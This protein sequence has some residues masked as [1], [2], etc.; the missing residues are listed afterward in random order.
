MNIPYIEFNSDEISTFEGDAQSNTFLRITV[1]KGNAQKTP[2][3]D[4]SANNI[5][6]NSQMPNKYEGWLLVKEGNV[7]INGD[8]KL[9]S[10]T[11]LPE[12]NTLF[13]EKSAFVLNNPNY[14]VNYSKSALLTGT[15]VLNQGNFSIG[16][17]DEN[18]F[19]V[20]QSAAISINGGVF[21]VAGKM[22]L[23][24]KTFAF[25]EMNDGEFNIGDKANVN[26]KDYILN[27]TATK[28]LLNGGKINL[29][30]R[31]S[32]SNVKDFMGNADVKN[33]VLAIGTPFQLN[34]TFKLEG[35]LPTLI[36]KGGATATFTNDAVFSYLLSIEKNGRLLLGKQGAF[37]KKNL[38]NAGE[39]ICQQGKI[40]F[41]G[42]EAQTIS[43]NGLFGTLAYPIQNLEIKNEKGVSVLTDKNIVIQNL[44]LKAGNLSH[45]N[46][47]LLS[48]P[49]EKISITRG[50][51]SGNFVA[52]TLSKTPQYGT[53]NDLSLVYINSND[54]ML[55]GEE[56]PAD[57]QVAE[58]TINTTKNFSLTKNIGI[59]KNLKLEKGKIILNNF[60]LSASENVVLK[61]NK[62][63]YIVTNGEGHLRQVV[64]AT[65]VSF[66]IGSSL[67]S[68]DPVVLKNDGEADVFEVKVVQN[69][70]NVVNMTKI[71]NRQWLVKELV[72]GKSKLSVQLTYDT[73]AV[74]GN[75]F[76]G[77]API[78]IAVS[79]SNVWVEKT[80]TYLGFTAS[81][82][83]ITEFESFAI[84]NKSAFSVANKLS[85]LKAKLIGGN[86]FLTWT[87][88]EEYNN[89]GFEI[90]KSSDLINFEKIAFVESRGNNTT[91]ANYSFT[92]DNF[93]K[94]SYYRLKQINMSDGK[95]RYSN[96]AVLYKR[97]NNDLTIFPNPVKSG[98]PVSIKSY[99]NKPYNLSIYD[100]AGR[101][102][103]TQM[104]EEK[105]IILDTSRYESGVYWVHT[106]DE[107]GLYSISKLIIVLF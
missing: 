83:N 79:N 3:L 90:E 34:H 47:L 46:N 84:G 27:L 39:I 15:L 91:A 105:T 51:D 107:N 75:E 37:I 36:I 28:C 103:H 43:G 29:Q 99:E 80:A 21:T 2:N 86:T 11:F 78:F 38:D 66:P 1:D 58:M 4:I 12:G 50:E 40:V 64:A 33:T 106:S 54:M 102:M 81:I 7:S 61:G 14:T 63:A 18:G 59:S 53:T 101:L 76:D 9:S 96:V 25:F 60:N 70:V 87:T 71:V 31:N 16:N 44:F 94:T 68:Y 93:K 55:S 23:E 85:E 97:E 65:K 6:A 92:D 57:G 77:K 52:G 49:T 88:F 19:V 5:F 69:V 13:P 42:D 45:N 73:K 30:T 17:D 98:L 8:F 41:D 10:P 24:N 20:A 26:L 104:V 74:V 82:E 67:D 89:K 48:H 100:S 35:K 72:K 62:I 32:N 95:S 22:A 56:F